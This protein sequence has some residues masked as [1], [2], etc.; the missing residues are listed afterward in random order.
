MIQF[1]A[2]IHGD[3]CWGPFDTFHEAVELLSLTSRERGH[4]AEEAYH[5][6]LKDCAIQQIDSLDDSANRFHLELVRREICP[7]APPPPEK[8]KVVR[9]PMDILEPQP[10]ADCGREEEPVTQTTSLRIS[11]PLPNRRKYAWP[12]EL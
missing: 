5:F 10:T 12:S 2:M 4:T 1:F 7:K 9:F 6:F 8:R 11:G 3:E